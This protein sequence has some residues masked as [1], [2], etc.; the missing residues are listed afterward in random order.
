MKQPRNVVDAF[1]FQRRPVT[2]LNICRSLSELVGG[3]RASPVSLDSF[4]Y[5]AISA[6]QNRHSDWNKLTLGGSG[7]APIR[8][9]PRTADATMALRDEEGRKKKVPGTVAH[10]FEINTSAR[11]L[12]ET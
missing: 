12:P 8:G 7:C 3:D 2:F 1:I 5:F 6:C 10:R 9:K 11:D 4:F